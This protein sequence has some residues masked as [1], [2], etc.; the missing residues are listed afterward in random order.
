MAPT[1]PFITEE[2]YQ[3]LATA[4]FQDK[5]PQSVHLN[6]WP[7]LGKLTKAE[8]DLLENMEIVKE[9]ASLGNA[10]RKQL[11]LPLRQPLAAVQVKH[12]QTK[13]K[14]ALCQILLEELNVK[15]V[16]WEQAGTESE[17][18]FDTNLTKELKDEG[19]ARNLIRT[20]QEA[21]KKAGVERD[22]KIIL[23][24]PDW[25]KAYEAEIKQKAMVK[26]L[27]KGAKIEIIS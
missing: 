11:N 3:N 8:E 4:D 9:V 13:P 17:V 15:D 26:E 2:I 5:H 25:P 18:T 1:T 7:E 27:K 6:D 19:E 14:T 12:R 21:R 10:V 20:I 16:K 24:L 22:L 23:T